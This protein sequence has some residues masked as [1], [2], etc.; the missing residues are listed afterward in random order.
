MTYDPLDVT[1]DTVGGEGR[2]GWGK[3][4]LKISGSKLLWFGSEGVLKIFLEKEDIAGNQL[5][6]KQFVGTVREVRARSLTN[7]V[8]V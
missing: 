6:T 2:G 4:S 1:R 3:P 5:L 7:C 8:N